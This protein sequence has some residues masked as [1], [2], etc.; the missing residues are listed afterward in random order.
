M[1]AKRAIGINAMIYRLLVGLMTLLLFSAC[2]ERSMNLDVA[3]HNYWPRAIYD[4]AVDGQYAGG[5]FMA[6]EPGNVGGKVV[7]C[8]GVKP[9][10][11]SIEYSLGGQRWPRKF[12]QSGKW[13]ARGL[14]QR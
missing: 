10:P 8:V 12:G 2:S 1:K 4:V 5:A 9:G 6:Y 3:I 7:C 13:N 14:S 11:I